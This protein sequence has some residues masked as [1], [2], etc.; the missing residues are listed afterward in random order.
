MIAD[1]VG[2]VRRQ[3]HLDV[4][5]RSVRSIGAG[6]VLQ[7]AVHQ[8]LHRRDAAERDDRVD[9]GRRHRLDLVERFVLG[10]ARE[11]RSDTKF[12]H[13]QRRE[14]C[15]PAFELTIEIAAGVALAARIRTAGAVRRQLLVNGPR[16]RLIGRGPVAVAAAEHPVAHLRERVLRQVAAKPFDELRGVIGRRAIVGGAENQH[17]ALFRQLADE[18]IERRELGGKAIDLGEIGD[19]GREFLGGAEVRPVEHQQR[20]VVSRTRPRARRR[21]GVRCRR[22]RRGPAGVSAAILL[23]ARPH[24]DLEAVRLDGQRFLQ[25]HL[26]AVDDQSA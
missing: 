7:F 11:V 21:R 16:N 13:R 5:G 15:E 3:L 26:I 17:A 18:I 6:F 22:C 10:A 9:H 14:L 25:L 12:L 2:D 20:R 19:A 8:H 24:L 1:A 23:G 4:P